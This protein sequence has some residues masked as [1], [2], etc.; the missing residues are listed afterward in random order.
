MARV[1][2]RNIQKTKENRSE[3][4]KLTKRRGKKQLIPENGVKQ[5]DDIEGGGQSENQYQGR[6]SRFS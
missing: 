1:L 6:R 4:I 5:I 3:I 2:N